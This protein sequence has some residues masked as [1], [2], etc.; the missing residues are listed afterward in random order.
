MLMKPSGA[1]PK[2]QLLS[3]LIGSNTITV[4]SPGTFD[5]AVYDFNGKTIAKGQLTNGINNINT[6]A[7][8]GGMYL[9]RFAKDGEQWTDKIIRQ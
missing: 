6:N 3:N 5:F 7:M 4:T 1:N 9:I 8:T 2:P